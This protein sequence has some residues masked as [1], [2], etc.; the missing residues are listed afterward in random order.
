MTMQNLFI[1]MSFIFQY[2]LYKFCHKLVNSFELCKFQED[3]STRFSRFR[4]CHASLTAKK[5]SPGCARTEHIPYALRCEPQPG[6]RFIR[7]V[8]S[9]LQCQ[10]TF[11]ALRSILSCRCSC[12]P[13]RNRGHLKGRCA[14]LRLPCSQ[15]EPHSREGCS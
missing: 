13:I 14:L 6:D 10:T 8:I 12:H 11:R 9:G 15:R 3:I 5:Q 2:R 1:I 7:Y 4:S